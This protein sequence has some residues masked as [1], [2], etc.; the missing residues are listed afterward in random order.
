MKRKMG[1][2]GADLAHS[3][4]SLLQ[5]LLYSVYSPLYF[6]SLVVLSPVLYANRHLVVVVIV[7][8]SFVLVVSVV[9]DV[10]TVESLLSAVVD[11]L[12]LVSSPLVV[13]F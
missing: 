12:G 6:P 10:E 9:L 2:V 3:Q 11:V 7:A 1:V 8:I 13:I 4:S 5:F